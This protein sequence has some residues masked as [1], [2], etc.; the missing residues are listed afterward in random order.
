[1]N[2]ERGEI[3]AVAVTPVLRFRDDVT[4]RLA[5]DG[6][7]VM[8]NVRSRFRVGKGDF[9]ANARRIRRFQEAFASR[10]QAGAG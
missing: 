2:R 10:L 7:G 8:V 6:D 9:G 5:R 1:M 3:R 4:F